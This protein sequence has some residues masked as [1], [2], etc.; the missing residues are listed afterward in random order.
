[1]GQKAHGAH[2]FSSSRDGVT[3]RFVIGD[4][5]AMYRG[6]TPA[7][8][9]HRHA[10]FQIVIGVDEVVAVV[11]AEGTRH[12][13]TALVITPMEKHRLLDTADA[14]IY[15]VEPHCLLADRLRRDYGNGVM[16]APELR[17]L[18]EGDVHPADP[19]PAGD[20]DPRLVQALNVLRDKNI[21]LPSVAASVG[22]SPQRLRALARRQLGMPLARWRVWTRLRRAAEALQGGQSP[23]EAAIAGGFA[24]QAHFTRQMRDMMGL[25]PAAVLP[26]LHGH[27]LRP[28]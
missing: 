22:L 2:A 14:V 15:F 19:R 3:P 13:S 1:L 9:L 4:G 16:T 6:S 18:T 12:Q 10:A 7:G 27:S 11:D 25:T 23:A 5:Y 26:L 8:S 17:E 28:T 20:L 24:D 21:P